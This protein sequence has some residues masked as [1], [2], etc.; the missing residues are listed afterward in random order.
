[1]LRNLA[2]ASDWC[3]RMILRFAITVSSVTSMIG[4]TSCATGSYRAANP[5]Q[6]LTAEQNPKKDAIVGMWFSKGVVNMSKNSHVAPVAVVGI[7]QPP[8][9]HPHVSLLLSKDGSGVWRSIAKD[10]KVAGGSPLGAIRGGSP[11]VAI[12]GGLVGY[13]VGESVAKRNSELVTQS[14][15]RWN[16]NEGGVWTL[17]FFDAASE[18]KYKTL[19]LG[20][21]VKNKRLSPVGSSCVVRIAGGR[22]LISGAGP[23]GT[24][25]QRVFDLAEKLN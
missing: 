12:G 25:S 10:E 6:G 23:D 1:M 5:F 8:L 22:L 24:P 15:L 3:P 13:L 18:H 7:H 11:L 2:A 16:Y 14:N 20:E 4:L 19:L 9:P 17:N 21:S